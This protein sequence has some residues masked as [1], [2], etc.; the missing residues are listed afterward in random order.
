MSLGQTAGHT[1]AQDVQGRLAMLLTLSAGALLSTMASIG[2]TPFLLDVARDLRT[3]LSA[4][5]NLVALQSVSWGV[6]SVFAGRLR[7]S[8][9]IG[10]W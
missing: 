7:R 8:S 9:A 1:A 3:D 10:P 6:A 5:S 4:S 2:I